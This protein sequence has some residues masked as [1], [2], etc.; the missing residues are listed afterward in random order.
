MDN[1]ETKGLWQ[2]IRQSRAFFFSL[3][4]ISA[5]WLVSAMSEQKTF[6]EQYRLA[7]DGIDYNRYAVTSADS[8]LVVDITSNGFN[9]LRRS[10]RK[11]KTIHVS[12]AKQIEGQNDNVKVSLDTEEI[13]DIV[14]NQIDNQGVSAFKIVNST[15][16]LA[17]A[18]RESKAFVPNIDNVEFLFDGMNGLCGEPR[19]MPDTVFLYGSHASLEKVDELRAQPQT[20]KHI[21]MSGKYRVRLE[22]IWE[23]Y[24]ELHPSTESIDIY[25]PVETFI[26]KTISL[27]VSFS[28]DNVKRVQLY[29]STVTVKCL[30][31]RKLYA[32]IAAD[33]FAVTAKPANDSSSYLVPVVTQ[34]PSYVRIKSISPERVQYIIIK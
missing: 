31:P 22:P 8:T 1:K 29:P 28:A 21:R 24:P 13:V 7:L 27:P 30:V 15:I 23:K 3:I 16:S 4:A 26:E 25:L 11:N 6:R 17:M 12:V 5:I 9:A 20:L 33:D 18:L 19:L 32:N 10:V 14:R 2:R 34:F